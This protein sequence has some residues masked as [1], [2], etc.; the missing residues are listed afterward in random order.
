MIR[1]EINN[2]LYG[3]LPFTIANT[4]TILPFLFL[5]TVVFTIISYWSIGLHEGASH[6]FRWLAFLFLG[7]VA[8]EF[9]SLLVASIFPIFVVALAITA[10]LNG[11]WM[12]TQGYF[13]KAVNLPRFWYVN[14]SYT[15]WKILFWSFRYYWAHW[16][17]YETFAFVILSY[18]DLSNLVFDCSGSIEDNTCQCSFSSSL[19]SQGQCAVSGDDVLRSLDYDGI[20]MTLYAFL[21]VI[22]I[23]VYR[24]LFYIVLK[25]K[26]WLK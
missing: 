19:V 16:I 18:S 6:F 3:P 15:I 8:A 12:V 17:N 2:K 9:Q 1:R 7:L 10:F 11:F 24:V 21:V 26:K 20:S 5:C 22:I 13:I 25:Y 14:V 23:L 4:L